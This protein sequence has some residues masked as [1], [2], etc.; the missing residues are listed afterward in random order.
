MILR[1]FHM[2]Q[3]RAVI[4]L[5]QT[6][7]SASSLRELPPHHQLNSGCII[8]KCYGTGMDLSLSA[9][10]IKLQLDPALGYGDH[11]YYLTEN[12]RRDI[13]RFRLILTEL[14]LSFGQKFQVIEYDMMSLLGTEELHM[15]CL[16]FPGIGNVISQFLVANYGRSVMDIDRLFRARPTPASDRLDIM[17]RSSPN[18]TEDT[19]YLPGVNRQFDYNLIELLS[20][21]LNRFVHRLKSTMSLKIGLSTILTCL[22]FHSDGKVTLT[23][24]V[25]DGQAHEEIVI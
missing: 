3:Q 2:A 20:R 6:P 12:P 1:I 11:D 19:I 25:P 4:V 22:T 10:M 17:L 13:A 15:A 24:I 7:E 8:T 16:I 21:N 14:C 18:V 9:G 5:Y 23:S